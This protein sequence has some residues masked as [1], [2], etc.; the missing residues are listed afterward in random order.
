MGASVQILP[1][2]KLWLTGVS[3]LRCVHFNLVT[4]IR[5]FWTLEPQ[6]WERGTAQAT[7][8]AKCHHIPRLYCLHSVVPVRNYNACFLLFTSEI[9]IGKQVLSVEQNLP[10]SLTYP[11]TID[12]NG[13][14][15]EASAVFY[16]RFLLADLLFQEAGGD[17]R[18]GHDRW[19]FAECCLLPHPVGGS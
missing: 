10:M 17:A 13:T 9:S 7:H 1:F 19:D 2:I 16:W 11:V 12:T 6:Q 5:R 15:L 4:S 18:K 8:T 3:T 14:P